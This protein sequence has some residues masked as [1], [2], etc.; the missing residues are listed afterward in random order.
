LLI[1]GNFS[2]VEGESARIQAARNWRRAMAY[3]PPHEDDQG[4][5][6]L[7]SLHQGDGLNIN[8]RHIVSKLKRSRESFSQFN[9]S[10]PAI[11]SSDDDPASENYTGRHR[12]KKMY[13]GPWYNPRPLQTQ[14]QEAVVP[15]KKRFYGRQVDSGVFMGSDFSELDSDVE[16]P[17]LHTTPE[18][19]R[20]G[21]LGLSHRALPMLKPSATKEEDLPEQ[22]ARDIIEQCLERNLVNIDLR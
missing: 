14:R 19:A 10:D 18:C 3:Q 15:V 21:F 7:P 5:P 12:A 4:S 16:V 20:K 22:R 2:I 6:Q 17:S 11:F 1:S 13:E 9:S 8:H